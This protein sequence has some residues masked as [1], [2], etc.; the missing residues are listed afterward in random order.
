MQ[1]SR[2]GSHRPVIRLPVRDEG[3]DADDRVVDVLRE[4]VADRLTDFCVGLADEIIGGCEPADVRHLLSALQPVDLTH[5]LRTPSGRQRLVLSLGSEAD[6]T[7]PMRALPR[8]QEP[9][10]ASRTPL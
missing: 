5:L 7:R 2:Q 9:A 4:L 1:T 8:A 3:S 6:V 10:R